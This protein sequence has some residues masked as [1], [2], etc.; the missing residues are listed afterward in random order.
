MEN[1]PMS[2]FFESLVEDFPKTEKSLKQE[3]I[4]DMVKQ[5]ISSKCS[6]GT[7][8]DEEIEELASGI[9]EAVEQYDFVQNLAG[10]ICEVCSNIASIKKR[11]LI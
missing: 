3:R 5:L 7:L 1:K 6:L 8:S 4:F 2:V 10:K 9:P 11:H